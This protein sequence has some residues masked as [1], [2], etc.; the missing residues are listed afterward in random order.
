MW[1]GAGDAR[2]P[3]RE[4]RHYPLG[5]RPAAFRRRRGARTLTGSPVTRSSALTELLSTRYRT[6]PCGLD[7]YDPP[8]SKPASFSLPLPPRADRAARRQA[9]HGAGTRASARIPVNRSPGPGRGRAPANRRKTPNA[10]RHGTAVP[11]TDP[12]ASSRSSQ[13]SIP[14][15]SLLAA[16]LPPPASHM[17]A[18]N[19][20]ERSNQCM[21]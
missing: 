20:P 16:R 13:P 19:Q 15:C 10:K 1:C 9:R 17:H 18:H 4:Q 3:R 11:H 12:I 6:S 5:P 2:G 14:L 21:L 7:S 8:V